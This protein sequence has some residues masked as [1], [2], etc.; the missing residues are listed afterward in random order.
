M[1]YQLTSLQNEIG[2]DTPSIWR[3]NAGPG[4]NQDGSV[5]SMQ[6]IL[7]VCGTEPLSVHQT[8]TIV[9]KI[10]KCELVTLGVITLGDVK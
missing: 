3:F 4:V 7:G 5:F 6:D 8:H 10:D 1:Y 9:F 2:L